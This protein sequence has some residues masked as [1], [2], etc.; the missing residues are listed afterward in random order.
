MTA[1]G[2]AL[3]SMESDFGFAGLLGGQLMGVLCMAGTMA[4]AVDRAVQKDV[5]RDLTSTN[6]QYNYNDQFDNNIS[7]S[8]PFS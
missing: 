8:A 2:Y 7:I 6:I 4:S 5:S 1:G 3:D